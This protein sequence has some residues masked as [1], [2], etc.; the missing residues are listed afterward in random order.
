MGNAEAAFQRL[1]TAI[2]LQPRNRYLARADSDFAGV[3]EYSP[4][5]SLLHPTG[6]HR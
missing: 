4:L 2:D 1:K 5:A 3:R 6:P